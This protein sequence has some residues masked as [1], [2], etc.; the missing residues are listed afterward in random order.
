MWPKQDKDSY[1]SH[2]I[3]KKNRIRQ[4]RDDLVASRLLPCFCSTSLSLCFLCEVASLWL[5]ELQS[6]CLYSK[7]QERE[8]A[9]ELPLS[10]HG[11]HTA[12]KGDWKLVCQLNV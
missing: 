4:L 8:I 12:A 3:L 11:P 2:V 9:K 7:H 6:S 10:S 1:L 5:L